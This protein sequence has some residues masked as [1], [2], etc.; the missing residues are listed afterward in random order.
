MA[1]PGQARYDRFDV[2]RLLAA[3]LS[4]EHLEEA[5]RLLVRLAFDEVALH[6]RTQ[7]VERASTQLAPTSCLLDEELQALIVEC[8]DHL[9]EPPTAEA[10]D[11]WATTHGHPRAFDL[12]LRLAEWSWR[13]LVD[14]ALNGAVR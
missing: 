3:R 12:T 13:R 14:R 7:L 8:A 11:A 6:D 1:G 9:G 10:Y 5:R 4:G 2:E